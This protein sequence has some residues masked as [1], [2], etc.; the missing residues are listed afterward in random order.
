FGDMEHQESSVEKFEKFTLKIENFSRLDKAILSEPFVLGGFPWMIYLCTGGNVT[1]DYLSIYLYAV[2]TANVSEGWSRDVKLKFCVF[3]LVNTN[4]TITKRSNYKFNERDNFLGFESFM[5]LAELCD[6]N[7][8]FLLNNAF[9]VGIEV[10]VCKSRNEKQVNQAANLTASLKP[11]LEKGQV[12]IVGELMD[13]KGLGH[14]EKAFVPL[15]NQVCSLHPL[16][17]ECQQKRSRQ[18]REWA[19]TALGRVLYFLKTRKVRDMN[20]LACKDLQIL[21]E[22]LEPFGFDLRWL[23][24][25]VKSALGLRSYLEKVKEAEKLKDNVVAL[26]LEMLRVKANLDS[27]K[28]LLEAEDFQEIDLDSELGFV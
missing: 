12:Q 3:S 4:T 26:E 19:F 13:F 9:I 18:F 7:K 11:K 24:P 21:W 1:G 28:Y 5:T 15:L 17:I 2:Q 16:L 10:Y 23:E 14:I 27:A 25:H 22:E 20:D 6:P 8:G